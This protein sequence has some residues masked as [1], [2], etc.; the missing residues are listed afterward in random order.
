MHLRPRAEAAGAPK[1]QGGGTPEAQGGGDG[2]TWGPG[3]RQWAG[4][5]L[6]L[7]PT[8][9]S[10]RSVLAGKMQTFAPDIIQG[11]PGETETDSDAVL[12]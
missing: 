6:I 7:F 11:A 5:C 4:I 2:R 8:G 9:C 3:Q 12:Y 10:S 1:A